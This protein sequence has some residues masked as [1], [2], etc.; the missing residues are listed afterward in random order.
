MQLACLKDSGELATG[1][2]TFCKQCQAVFNKHSKIEEAKDLAGEVE[3]IWNC[4]FCNTK[5]IVQFDA[6][7]LPKTTGVTYIVEAAA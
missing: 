7:E 2:P 3:Q 4:E 6:E 5:N 1:D